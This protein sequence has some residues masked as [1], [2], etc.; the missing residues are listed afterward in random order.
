MPQPDPYEELR[1]DMRQPHQATL[2]VLCRPS[3][4]LG[5]TWR[6]KT[7]PA[8]RRILDILKDWQLGL[9]HPCDWNPCHP[10]QD[11]L[12]GAITHEA[13]QSIHPPV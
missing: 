12:R 4:G 3:N 5:P 11:A 10:P 13:P 2:L 1:I 8:K 7:F 6:S 9:I